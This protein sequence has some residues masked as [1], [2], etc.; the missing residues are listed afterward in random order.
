[1]QSGPLGS[2]SDCTVIDRFA[3]VFSPRPNPA[4]VPLTEI[5]FCRVSS[6]V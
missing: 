6:I 4:H 2:L 1:M 5:P 3:G